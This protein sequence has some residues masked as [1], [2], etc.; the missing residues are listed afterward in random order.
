MAEKRTVEYRHANWFELIFGM[1]NNGNGVCFYLLMM[2][3]SYIATE[4]YG[5]A[6]ATMGIIATACRLFDAVTDT[7]FGWLFDIVNPKKGKI[8]LFLVGGFAIDAF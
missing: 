8:R 5:I 2:Y 7:F 6:I 1:A 3:A 4:G